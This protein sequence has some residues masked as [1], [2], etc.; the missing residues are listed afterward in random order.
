MKIEGEYVLEGPQDVVWQ[1]LLDPVVLASVLPGCEKLE[2]VG[3]N[4]YDGALNI[5]VGPVQGQFQG[6]VLVVEDNVVN[7]QVAKRFLQRLGCQVVV[8]ENGKRGVDEFFEAEAGKQRF[9]LVLMDVQMPVMDGLTAAREIRG[10]ETA[11]RTP[12]VALTASAMT[13]E[14]ERCTAAGM[15]ALLV[16]PLAQAEAD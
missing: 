4:E 6:R 15:D 13:D 5:K 8:A 1:T 10:R 7:Q 11:G 2:L 9:G 14:L 16:K 12:I 3:E